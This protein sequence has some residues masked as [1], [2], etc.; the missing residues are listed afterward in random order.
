MSICLSF[1]NCKWKK[2][3]FKLPVSSKIGEHP[4]YAFS[5]VTEKAIQ[6]LSSLT[7]EE[8][9]LLNPFYFQNLSVHNIV[10]GKLPYTGFQNCFS[11]LLFLY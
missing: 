8:F 3:L 6:K 10:P 11:V 2:S 7:F 4:N 9:V 5:S 1:I